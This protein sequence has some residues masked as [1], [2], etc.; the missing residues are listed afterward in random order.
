MTDDYCGL[1][2]H[3][4]TIRYCML[5]PLGEVVSEGT[6]PATCKG[7][8]D[9]LMRPRGSRSVT[10]EA[11]LFS[12]WIYDDLQPRVDQVQVAHPLMLKAL[13]ASKKKS[14]V[15]DAYTIAKLSR[16]RLVVKSYMMPPELRHL[17]TILQFRNLL[18]RQ[19]V[20]MK[21]KTAGLLMEYGVEYQ[22][23]RLHRPSYQ[24]I[25]LEQLTEFDASCRLL[26]GLSRNC[27]CFL[28]RM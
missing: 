11:T 5:S 27:V 23:S 17:R 9:W 7:L 8:D 26:F 2:V 24:S 10:L 16:C 6:I 3:K 12:A 21:N 22:K 14:D 19:M 28:N 15:L 4:K 20:Q 13:A 25:L 1:D 18:V